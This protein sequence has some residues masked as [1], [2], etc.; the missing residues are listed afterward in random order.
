MLVR[1]DWEYIPLLGHMTIPFQEFTSRP[2]TCTAIESLTPLYD[3]HYTEEEIH[4]A[5]PA[6]AEPSPPLGF[7]L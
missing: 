5:N 6:A 7:P 4:A 1:M 2:G 3:F